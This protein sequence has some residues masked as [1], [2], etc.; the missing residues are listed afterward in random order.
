MQNNADEWR[1]KYDSLV[2]AKMERLRTL[3]PDDRSELKKAWAVL[4]ADVEAA[5]E[6]S[7]R[8]AEPGGL[9]SDTPGLCAVVTDGVE[10]PA[11]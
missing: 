11:R 3:S 7:T 10:V 1:K 8:Q 4:V 2:Q 9:H 6:P 5:L